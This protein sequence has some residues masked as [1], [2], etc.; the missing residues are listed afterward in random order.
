MP[1]RAQLWTFTVIEG[2]GADL[3]DLGIA[4]VHLVADEDRPMERSMAVDRHGSRS[5]PLARRVADGAAGEVPSAD[6]QPGRPKMSPCGLASAGIAMARKGRARLWVAV[7]MVSVAGMGEG[8]TVEALLTRGVCH[9]RQVFVRLR[10]VGEGLDRAIAGRENRS[11]V[12]FL[13]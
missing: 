4:G 3:D 9:H 10:N 8:V 11:A 7:G 5:G 12:F 13:R 6:R 1:R 2:V